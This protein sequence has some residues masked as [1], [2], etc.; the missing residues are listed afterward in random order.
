MTIVRRGANK[1]ACC[2]FHKEKTPSFHI[3]DERGFYHCF[4]CGVSGDVISYVRATEGLEFDDAVR[5]LAEDY[6]IELP[7]RDLKSIQKHRETGDEK[8]I[9]LEINEATCQFF[10]KYMFSEAG[11]MGLNY[12]AK[13][14][15]DADTLKK[16]RIGF[17]PNSFNTLENYLKNLG[18]KQNMLI[19]A[20]VVSPLQK[21]GQ[22]NINLPDADGGGKDISTEDSIKKEDNSLIKTANANTNSPESENG[23]ENIKN[24]ENRAG[25]VDA[26]AICINNTIDTNMHGNISDEVKGQQLSDDIK[27]RDKFRNRVM[28]PVLDNLGKVIAFSGRVINSADMPKYMNSPETPVFHKGDV[29]FNYYFAKKAIAASRQAILT[30]GN[31]DALSLSMCG[32][33]N[34]VAPMGTA[35]TEQQIGKLWKVADEILVCL[36]GDAAG[37]KAMKRLAI[38]LLPLL[39]ADRSVKFCS[40]PEGQDPDDF[41]RSHGAENFRNY[42][43]DNKNTLPLSEFLWQSELRELNL[44]FNL[45]G[46][47]SV[48]SEEISPETKSNLELHLDRIVK[49]IRDGIVS[50]NFRDFYRNKL[51]EISRYG[52]KKRWNG[53]RNYKKNYGTDAYGYSHGSSYNAGG[54]GASNQNTFSGF[55]S[56]FSQGS[57][58]GTNKYI[59][60]Q[61]FVDKNK[62]TN[63]LLRKRVE[64]VEKNILQLLLNRSTLPQE[65]F[66][67]YAIDLQSINFMNVAIVKTIDAAMELQNTPN[68]ASDEDMGGADKNMTAAKVNNGNIGDDFERKNLGEEVANIRSS[69]DS[70]SPNTVENTIENKDFLARNIEKNASHTYIDKDDAANLKKAAENLSPLLPS[71]RWVEH[72]YSMLLERSALLLE[73]ELRELGSDDADGMRRKGIYEELE[74]LRKRKNDLDSTLI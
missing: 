68:L 45:R 3:D 49:S 19:M 30:E 67:K 31:L 29:L 59:K 54:Y 9:I 60:S 40:L 25:G 32:I 37:Q 23:D 44:N 47:D 73:L 7:K 27:I 43:A 52:S 18:F 8:R 51:F 12:M 63:D 42:I 24:I 26:V 57:G 61:L 41:V 36:D 33:E 50:K 71:G 64:N 62:S 72:L 21:Q 70:I 66:E 16:F 13:R 55:I 15:M 53:N 58:I 74:A 34:V 14:G 22:K 46:F 35:I 65:I 5:K 17:A 39:L 11:R 1:V 6:G 38:M 56:N 28:F 4:G 48:V 10:E 69:N 20:G 2:P